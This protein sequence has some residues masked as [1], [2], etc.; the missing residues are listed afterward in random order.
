M[1]K[2]PLICTNLYFNILYCFPYIFWE[3]CFLFNFVFV[4]YCIPWYLILHHKV[5][6]LCRSQVKRTELLLK[7]MWPYYCRSR[8]SLNDWT[9]ETIFLDYFTHFQSWENSL[10]SEE[11]SLCTRDGRQGY[12]KHRCRSSTF[13][14]EFSN[15]CENQTP[16]N[17]NDNSLW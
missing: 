12:R 8:H 1:H 4:I 3:W 14:G 9:I 13:S 5:L 16:L 10:F 7:T 2:D 15:M 6:L 11:T 17:S